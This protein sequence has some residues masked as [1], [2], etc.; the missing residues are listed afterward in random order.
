MGGFL[1]K[2]TADQFDKSLLRT[3]SSMKAGDIS[4]PVEVSYGLST[5]YHIV[6]L[7]GR[8]PEHVMNLNDDWRR[9]EQ[10]ATAYKKNTE[11]Q[12]WIIQ[13]RKEIYW[14]VRL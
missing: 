6:Y 8:I 1:G 2:L 14:E 4:S 12:Q 9:L 5:G 3:V 10:L 7:K 11:Y 13:L